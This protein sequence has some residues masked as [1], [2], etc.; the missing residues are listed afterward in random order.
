MLTFWMAASPAATFLA[1][2]RVDS[3]KITDG[4]DR[5]L[6]LIR[7]NPTGRPL[8]VPCLGEQALVGLGGAERDHHGLGQVLLG[9]ISG[10]AV[11]CPSRTAAGHDVACISSHQGGEAINHSD[12]AM[13]NRLGLSDRSIIANA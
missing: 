7:G 1:R 10:Y 5:S 3:V 13:A 12:R 6:D 11:D 2:R 9:A 8:R 4:L